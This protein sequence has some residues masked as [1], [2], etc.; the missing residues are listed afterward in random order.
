MVD[1]PAPTQPNSAAASA[2]TSIPLARFQLAAKDLMAQDLMTRRLPSRWPLASRLPPV[3][4]PMVS[5][6]SV[7]P[8]DWELVAELVA[9]LLA[10]RAKGCSVVPHRSQLP[11]GLHF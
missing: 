4:P 3:L 9:G 8:L 2:T 11:R 6:F 10:S 5:D 7:A 1:L